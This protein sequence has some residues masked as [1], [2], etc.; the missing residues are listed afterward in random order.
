MKVTLRFDSFDDKEEL[1]RCIKATA[2]YGALFDMLESLR[3]TN[4]YSENEN[5]VL[6]SGHWMMILI[7]ILDDNNINLEEEYI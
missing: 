3:K 7:S 6:Y 1:A 5:E 4:K 2:A